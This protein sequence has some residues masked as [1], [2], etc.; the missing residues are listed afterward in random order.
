MD[1]PRDLLEHLYRTMIRIRLCEES[2]V[3]PILKGEI[4]T[5]CHLYS[6]EEGIAVGLCTALSKDDYVFGNHRSH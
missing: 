5:P 2:L 1:Y 4:C 3:E 6:G